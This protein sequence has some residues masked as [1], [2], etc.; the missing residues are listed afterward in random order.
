[1]SFGQRDHSRGAR[2]HFTID[3][4]SRNDSAV[5][6]FTVKATIGSQG[7]IYP[8]RQFSGQSIIVLLNLST[9]RELHQSFQKES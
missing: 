1:M 7:S 6:W 9:C 5:S 3:F 2:V 8:N 4:I